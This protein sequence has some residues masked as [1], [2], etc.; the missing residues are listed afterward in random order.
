MPI[1]SLD[2]LDDPLLAQRSPALA[3]LIYSI[4]PVL[5]KRL[6]ADRLPIRLVS[7]AKPQTPAEP[8]QGIPGDVFLR[9]L[10]DVE[11]ARMGARVTTDE[12]EKAAIYAAGRKLQAAGYD[13]V[14]YEITLPNGEK[15][16]AW[17]VFP[18]EPAKADED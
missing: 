16:N 17:W 4:G 15:T 10:R 9:A 12:D 5:A 13:S 2:E 11:L 1:V 18:D 14:H 6:L 8:G 7:D 3:G